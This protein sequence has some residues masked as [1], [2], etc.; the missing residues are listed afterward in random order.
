MKSDVKVKQRL[1]QVCNDP[2][3]LLPIYIF[4][5]SVQDIL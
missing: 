4:P 3:I 2:N 5:G 1:F